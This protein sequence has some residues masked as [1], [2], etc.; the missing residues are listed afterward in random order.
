MES[1]LTLVVNKDNHNNDL[2]EVLNKYENYIEKNYNFTT[3]LCVI[4]DVY[5]SL[6]MGIEDEALKEKFIK[7][8]QTLMK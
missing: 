3:A 5:K 4:S 7:H 2:F 1:K 6:L 8:I